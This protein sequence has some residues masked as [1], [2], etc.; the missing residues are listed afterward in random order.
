MKASLEFTPRRNT[1]TPFFPFMHDCIYLIFTPGA[2][3]RCSLTSYGPGTPPQSWTS[4]GS[5]LCGNSLCTLCSLMTM[6]A[7]P[8]QRSLANLQE[9][10]SQW[11]L[12]IDH[13]KEE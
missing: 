10:K 1:S 2:K 8:W 9:G 3:S 5:L 4:A 12:Q 13:P 6:D 11:V 7:L